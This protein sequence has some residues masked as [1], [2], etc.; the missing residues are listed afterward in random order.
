MC[1]PVGGLAGSPASG[2]KGALLKPTEEAMMELVKTPLFNIEDNSLSGNI[3]PAE[4]IARE[5]VVSARAVNI[6]VAK[7]LAEGGDAERRAKSVVENC[8][9]AEK[10]IDGSISSFNRK[11]NQYMKAER[12]VCDAA[13]QTSSK[14][15]DTTQKLADGLAKIEKVANLNLLESRVALLERAA[16]AMD[17]LAKLHDSGK[18]DKILAAIK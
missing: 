14:L 13:K 7:A 1:K 17:R 5:P 15:R 9:D 16:D 11:L 6:Y 2:D 10:I 18:L 8:E 12:E 4:G 3:T